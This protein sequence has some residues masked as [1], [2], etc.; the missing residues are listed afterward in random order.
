MINL[1]KSNARGGAETPDDA[2]HYILSI[3][4]PDMWRKD[5]TEMINIFFSGGIVAMVMN[6]VMNQKKQDVLTVVNGIL[7]NCLLE[8]S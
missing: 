3:R 4:F 2:I 7:G 8:L 6:F 5:Y 1:P